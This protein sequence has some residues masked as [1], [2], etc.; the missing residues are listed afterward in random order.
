[1]RLNKAPGHKES[2]IHEKQAIPDPRVYNLI[3]P[4]AVE[5]VEGS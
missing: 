1:M 2:R 4:K 3:A 5:L